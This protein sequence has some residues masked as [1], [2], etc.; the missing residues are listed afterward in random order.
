MCE[1]YGDARFSQKKKIFINRLNIGLPLWAWEKKTV[2]EVEKYWLFGKEKVPGA[3]V[4]K[5]G[6]A[7]R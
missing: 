1:V 5:E 2:H 6:D 7:E 4:C 3:V